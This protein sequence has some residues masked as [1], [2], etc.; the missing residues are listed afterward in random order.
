MESTL[1]LETIVPEQPPEVIEKQYAIDHWRQL[2]LFNPLTFSEEVHVIGCGAIGSHLVDSL[3]CMGIQNI[4]VYD[5]DRVEGHNI[6]NQVF[7]MRHIGMLKVDALASHVKEKCGIT[8]KTFNLK[9]EKLEKLTGYLVLCPDSMEA[10]KG[11][12]LSSAR[13]NPNV[14]SVIDVRMAVDW[15]RVYCID[16]MRK[17][18]VKKYLKDALS[19]SDAEAEESPCNMR[20][21]A[22]TAKT[23]AGMAAHRIIIVH[24]KDP[25]MGLYQSSMVGM[26]GYVSNS[27][28][29]N[30]P[31]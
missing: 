1:E 17:D 2:G 30:L 24:N 6:P 5:F 31:A 23:L 19:F 7:G 8:I 11:I 10:R 26:G 15:G 29:S 3:A 12:F 20:A 9:V 18:H 22:T 21:I 16:P 27:D 28:W 4:S 25:K 14:V 13:D